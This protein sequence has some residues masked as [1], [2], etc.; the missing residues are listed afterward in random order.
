M[1]AIRF[2]FLLAMFVEFAALTALAQDPV[3]VAPKAFKERLNNDNVRV[4][5]YSSKPG[6]KEALHSHGASVLYVIQGGK[7]KS[8]TPDGVSK[9]IEYKTGD[10]LW[11]DALTHTSENVGTTELKAIIIEVKQAKKK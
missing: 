9:E 5:E 11:R 3:K 2:L 8:T 4:V 10:V 7:F 6:Q 1:K